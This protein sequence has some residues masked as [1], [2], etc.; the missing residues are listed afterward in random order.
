MSIVLPA[1]AVAF[2][3]S[4]VW[5]GVRIFNRQERWATWTLAVVLLYTAYFVACYLATRGELLR[6]PSDL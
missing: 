6:I 2:A 5:L 3:A 1:L 4:C